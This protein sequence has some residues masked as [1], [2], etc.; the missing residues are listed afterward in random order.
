MENINDTRKN[1]LEG[2]AELQQYLTSVLP[3]EAAGDFRQSFKPI[4]DGLGL[5]SPKR[6]EAIFTPPTT[7]VPAKPQVE[8][9]KAAP[10]VSK[11]SVE[12]PSRIA[13]ALTA[14]SETKAT[15]KISEVLKAAPPPLPRPGLFRRLSAV[16]LDQV[17]AITLWAIALVITANAM[18]GFETGFS[19]RIVEDFANPTFVR[20]AALEFAGV[21][22]AYLTICL[23]V[24]NLTF[25]MWV[26]G[27]R[28]SYGPK[29]EEKYS[30]RK[31]MRIF[32]SFL[33]YAPIAP[34]LILAVRIHGRNLLDVLSG[35][36]VYVSRES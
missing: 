19:A 15:E 13:Q 23:G 26:W 22:L 31:I 18:N 34:L 28:I 2:L 8:A 17:F 6:M 35:S 1:D 3:E 21:W 11:P 5:E 36:S 30:L 24:L 33:F 9:P 14:E 27:I 25:G 12:T 32:W 20:F 4:T 7:P 16:F 29:E 10:L